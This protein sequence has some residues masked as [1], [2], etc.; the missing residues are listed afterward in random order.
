MEEEIQNSDKTIAIL[1][2]KEQKNLDTI[3]IL[4]EK[5]SA[6]EKNQK[7]SLTDTESISEGTQTELEIPIFC[8]E[9]DF[10]AEDYH[11]LGEHMMETCCENFESKESLD[12]HE[13]KHAMNGETEMGRLKCNFCENSFNAMREL[14][15]HKKNIHGDKCPFAE[16]LRMG[17]V[18]LE[19]KTVG[20]AI[21]E[22]YI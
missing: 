1:E 22:N 19:I 15:S 2:K 14:M 17:L 18:L 4:Q 21:L 5:V 9:C 20:S 10:P 3:K 8:Y 7:S 11:D 16:I 13:P 12:E 6:L